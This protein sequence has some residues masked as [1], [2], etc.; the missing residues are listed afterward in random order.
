MKTP[1]VDLSTTCVCVHTSWILIGVAAAAATHW[2]E[3]HKSYTAQMNDS[4]YSVY[5]LN[6]ITFCL[7]CFQITPNLFRI[8]PTAEYE[9][10][11]TYMCI[12]AHKRYLE[13]D[14]RD[15]RISGGA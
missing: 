9:A 13:A 3:G 1:E 6:N 5:M 14:K 15:F 11:E 7:W 8:I 2:L 4:D 10:Q 12:N